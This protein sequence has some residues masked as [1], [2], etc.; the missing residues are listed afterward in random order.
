ATQTVGHAWEISPE[1]WQRLLAVNLIGPI[2]VARA[3]IPR[4]AQSGLPG[5][6]ANVCSLGSLV[7][8]PV[9][10]AYITSKHALMGFSECLSLDLQDAGHLIGVSAVLPG[11]MAT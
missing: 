7:R 4:M 8:I 2:L 3:F 5:H 10:T 6:I 11:V 1:L 9:E